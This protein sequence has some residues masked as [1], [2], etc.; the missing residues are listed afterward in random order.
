[1]QN[2]QEI[3]QGWFL[4]I[5][6]ISNLVYRV[7]FTDAYGRIVEKTGIDPEDLIHQCKASA[8]DIEEQVIEKN[9]Q[10]PTLR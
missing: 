5:E 10:T 4:N 9:Q 2:G 7:R 1:M 3:I 8:L 6:E